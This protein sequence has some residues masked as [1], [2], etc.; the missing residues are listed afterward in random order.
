MITFGKTNL[1]KRDTVPSN[2]L[3]RIEGIKSYINSI[4]N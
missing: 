4:Y 3:E 1:K 2:Y